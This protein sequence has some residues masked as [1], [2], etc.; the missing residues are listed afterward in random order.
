MGTFFSQQ[1]NGKYCRFSTVSDTVEEYNCTAEYFVTVYK[2]PKNKKDREFK[3]EMFIASL[4]PFNMVK[5]AF[6]PRNESIEDFEKKLR[7]MGDGTGLGEDRIKK[8]K[9]NDLDDEFVSFETAKLLKEKGYDALCLRWYDN[10]GDVCA[11]FIDG[12]I[13]VNY[14]NDN[15][16]F[17]CPTRTAVFHFFR[18]KYKL[19]VEI[20]YDY[21][22]NDKFQFGFSVYRMGELNNSDDEVRQTVNNELYDTYEEAAEGAINYVLKNLI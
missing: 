13:P 15:Y 17:L 14:K 6:M 12:D 3:T 5:D 4:C 1:P 7:E 21:Y 18:L 10:K 9:A 22:E 16:H 20:D 19:F 2:N 8:I 11:K